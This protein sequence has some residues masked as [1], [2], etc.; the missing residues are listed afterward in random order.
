MLVLMLLAMASPLL[1]EPGLPERLRAVPGAL[2]ENLGT[3]FPISSNIEVRVSLRPLSD[4]SNIAIHHLNEITRLRNEIAEDNLSHEKFF[5]LDKAIN[6][7]MFTLQ[8]F[9][10]HK[11]RSRRGLINIVG[12]VAHSLFGVV[13]DDT[14]TSKFSEYRST[15]STI[16]QRFDTSIHNI[17]AIADNIQQLQ[18][19]YKN[20]SHTFNVLQKKINNA[21]HFT[22]LTF[23]VL[24]YQIT[25][26]TITQYINSFVSDLIAASKGT[27]SESLISPQDIDLI[28]K[29]AASHKLHPLFT[30]TD[31]VP[32]YSTLKSFLT[33]SGLSVFIPMEPRTSFTAY[34]IHPFPHKTNNT[35]FTL[36]LQHSLILKSSQGHTITTPPPTFMTACTQALPRLFVCNSRPLPLFSD[37][38]SDAIITNHNIINECSFD[39]IVPTS[40]PF[41]LPFD[42]IS[43]LYFFQPSTATVTC[44]E[45]LPDV[46]VTGIY[47]LPISCEIVTT[48]LFI[49]A[50]HS[51]ATDISVRGLNISPMVLDLPVFNVTIPDISTSH[52][53]HIQE[54]P[55]N[56]PSFTFHSIY[57]YP[58]YVVGAGMAIMGLLF[59]M[60][61]V[62]SYRHVSRRNRL[63]APPSPPEM[64]PL[65]ASTNATPRIL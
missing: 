23:N 3:V 45:A 35:F 6:S 19:A 58:I 46:V 16:S 38:C 62:I 8:Q 59:I 7:T 54:N 5:L 1:A 51:Y 27:V 40:R 26:N 17:N 39:S 48:S 53:T 33:I 24:S 64:V 15:L 49:P 65:D 50:S 56:I 36:Q 37:D 52:V 34:Y 18:H 9:V 44:K 10:V 25:V 43:V 42:D 4:I 47:V 31:R 29:Q 61:Y 12:K 32:F 41:H 21:S 57:Y 55:V 60:C 20:I 22:E 14:L 2:I 63:Y 11:R 28:L 30:L 13:D